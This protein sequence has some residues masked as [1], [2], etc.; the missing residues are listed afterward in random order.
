MKFKEI[1]VHSY[2]NFKIGQLISGI[3]HAEEKG[4]HEHHHSHVLYMSTC[5]GGE[6]ITDKSRTHHS[7]YV[8]LAVFLVSLVV[9]LSKL[10]HHSVRVHGCPR[11]QTS[12]TMSLE[13]LHWERSIKAF[14]VYVAMR[15]RFCSTTSA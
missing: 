1:L 4:F 11:E 3:A 14:W 15:A 8:S 7:L 6:N 12:K 13:I 5:Y 9:L 2:D 10:S